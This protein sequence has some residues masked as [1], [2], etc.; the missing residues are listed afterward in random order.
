MSSL[1]KK[2]GRQITPNSP[3]PSPLFNNPK[4]WFVFRGKEPTI[5]QEWHT[6]GVVVAVAS[7][8]AVVVVVDKTGDNFIIC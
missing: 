6:L 2:L 1:E 8:V 4:S 3:Y 7:V 5:S